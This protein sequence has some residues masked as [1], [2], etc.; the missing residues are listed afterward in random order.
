MKT[1]L[2]S[3]FARRGEDETDGS[4]A[5]VQRPL[6]HHVAQHGKHEGQRFAGTLM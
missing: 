2:Q 5:R 3:K 4:L 6:I 1:N